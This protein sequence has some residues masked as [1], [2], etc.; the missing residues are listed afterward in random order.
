LDTSH[1][2][3]TTIDL[4]VSPSVDTI[5]LLCKFSMQLVAETGHPS[6]DPARHKITLIEASEIAGGASGK[7]GGMLAQWDSQ[8]EHDLS[9]RVD[10][11]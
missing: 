7:A 1:D 8:R 9:R 6:Y 11:N 3:L 10:H 5:V 4:S 2:E